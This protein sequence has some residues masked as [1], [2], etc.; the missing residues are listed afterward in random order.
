MQHYLLWWKWY[1]R[2]ITYG[3]RHSTLF[4]EASRSTFFL[5]WFVCITCICIL[6]GLSLV[7]PLHFPAV[8]N[9]C[10][11]RSKQLLLLNQE[12]RLLSYKS[13]HIK[14]SKSHLKMD[15]KF[16][17]LPS[18]VAFISLFIFSQ[19]GYSLSSVQNIEK[20]EDEIHGY[21]FHTYFFQNNEESTLEALRFR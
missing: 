12:S 8:R 10:R 14:S 1:N 19:I 5:W 9:K 3:T 11:N 7:S 20:V 2:K 17:L 16:Y 15:N 6:T 13:W 18:L 21:H 4:H